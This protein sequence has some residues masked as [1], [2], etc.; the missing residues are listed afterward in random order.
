VKN[1]DE[2]VEQLAGR[3]GVTGRHLRRLFLQHLGATPLDVALTRR[4]H[5][6][7]KLLDETTLPINQVAFASGFGS[8]RRF[9]GQIRRTFKRTPDMI[10]YCGELTGASP[11]NG[12]RVSA[13][14]DWDSML[15]FLRTRATPSSVWTRTAIAALS[16]RKTGVIDVSHLA[17]VPPWRWTCAFPIPRLALHRRRVRRV[18]D[19]AP[20][21]R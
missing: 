16:R 11:W 12:T 19:L 2:G 7:K 9:N 1:D 17:R 5:F 20:I 21:P 13:A 14:Y 8:V 6:A 10:D 4:V 18:F 3:L 15:A